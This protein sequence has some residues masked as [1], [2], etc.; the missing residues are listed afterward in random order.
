MRSDKEILEQTEQLA[1]IFGQ[2][3]G[4]EVT[5]PNYRFQLSTNPRCQFMWEMACKAQE[6]L[7]DTDPN[8]CGDD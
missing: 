2:M 5:N 1:R 6:F 8:N 3:H 4:R 7:T